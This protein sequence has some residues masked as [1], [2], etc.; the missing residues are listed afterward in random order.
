MPA[1]RIAFTTRIY[2]GYLFMGLITLVFGV[3]AFI[4]LNTL[5]RQFNLQRDLSSS[6]KHATNL[7]FYAAE[8]Q[9]RAE[10]YIRVGQPQAAESVDIAYRSSLNEL[11]YLSALDSEISEPIVKRIDAHLKTFKQAFNTA[12]TQRSRRQKLVKTSIPDI[13]N[14][15]GTLIE[16]YQKQ[17]IAAGSLAISNE[18]WRDLLI[19]EKH[20]GQYFESLKSTE[21][22]LVDENY[23]MLWV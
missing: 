3:I 1:Q 20:M 15:W 16:A 18:I 6:L 14:S 12:K 22:K 7:G 11:S 23:N 10:T 13:T 9:S 5:D 2:S 19:I 4:G 21:L 8:M 17:T